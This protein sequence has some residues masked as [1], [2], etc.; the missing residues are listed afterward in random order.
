MV[1]LIFANSP[2]EGLWN[3][4][5]IPLRV[6]L[7][8][9]PFNAESRSWYNPNH[10]IA[11]EIEHQYQKEKTRMLWVGVGGVCES[12]GLQNQPEKCS[13]TIPNVATFTTAQRA[14]GQLT[15]AEGS[16]T[17]EPKA[18]RELKQLH[19]LNQMEWSDRETG[20]FGRRSRTPVVLD[21][22]VR[23]MNIL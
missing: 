13:V 11:R 12:P 2:G 17:A 16:V 7:L 15:A 23:I 14:E 1:L 18:Q 22:L 8:S 9:F 10:T 3:D 20:D 6:F 5:L 19:Y 4:D 21:S